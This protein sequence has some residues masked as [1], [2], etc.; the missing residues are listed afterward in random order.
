MDGSA[1]QFTVRVSYR[2]LLIALVLGVAGMHT[3]GHLDHWQRHGGMPAPPGHAS[4]ADHGVLKAYAEPHPPLMPQ[5][6]QLLAG[7]D[8]TPLPLDPSSVCLAVLTSVLLLLISAASLWTRHIARA[9]AAAASSA[10]LVARP[11]PRKTALRLACLSV[12][13]V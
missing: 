9:R 12:L 7:R 2:L 4:A 5:A 1:R 10:L 3:L 13:R 6:R 8:D 11:P